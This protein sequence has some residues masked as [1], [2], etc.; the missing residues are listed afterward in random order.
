VGNA[1]ALIRRLEIRAPF[2][3][4]LRLYFLRAVDLARLARALEQLA[5]R[6]AGGLRSCGARRRCHRAAGPGCCR[7]A[8]RWRRHGTLF[9]RRRG[10]R[11]LVR[12]EEAAGRCATSKA[13][14]E[15]CDEQSCHVRLPAC[16]IASRC[17]Q[18]VPPVA[19]ALSR[20]SGLALELERHLHLRPVGFNLSVLQHHVLR[21]DL[22]NP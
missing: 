7:S 8:L 13:E 10:R 22:R 16:F 21:D 2:R 17:L 14:N 4:E 9:R 6:G 15:H 5:R 12:R 19:A 11:R 1:I 18:H 20:T 3:P